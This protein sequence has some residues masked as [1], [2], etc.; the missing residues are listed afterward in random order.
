MGA[1]RRDGVDSEEGSQKEELKRGRSSLRCCRR[2]NGRGSGGAALTAANVAKNH[3][4]GQSVAVRRHRP[5]PQID[6]QRDDVA[7]LEHKIA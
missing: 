2:D 4:K 3:A 1:R 6:N 7:G 5:L